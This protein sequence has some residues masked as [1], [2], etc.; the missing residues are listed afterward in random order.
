MKPL[1]IG[2][3]GIAAIVFLFAAGAVMREQCIAIEKHRAC[4]NVIPIEVKSELCPNATVPCIAD[5]ALQQHNAIVD[6]IMLA[7]DDAKKA[8][9]SDES[10]N[11]RIKEVTSLLTGYSS[12]AMELCEQPGI[13]LAK[14]RYG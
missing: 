14:R 4:W 9:Y 7:C 13:V 3:I 11:S 12:G 2:I 1:F 6:A 5:P 8:Q 10:L